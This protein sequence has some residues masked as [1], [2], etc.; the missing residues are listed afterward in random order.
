LIPALLILLFLHALQLS[1]AHGSTSVE[2]LLSGK[3]GPS[4]RWVF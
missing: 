2:W 1:A 3:I 4:G